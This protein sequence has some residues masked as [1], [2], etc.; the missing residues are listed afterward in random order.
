MAP[1]GESAGTSSPGASE[2]D[3]KGESGQTANPKGDAGNAEENEQAADSAVTF[4]ADYVSKLRKEAAENRTKARD[5]AAKLKEHEEKDKPETEKLRARVAELESEK[6]GWELERRTAKVTAVFA[7]AASKA[8][9]TYPDTIGRLVDPNAIE[10]A[11]GEIMNAPDLVRDVKTRYPN[12]FTRA[13]AGSADGG[14]GNGSKPP[15]SSMNDY[16]RRAAG[17]Q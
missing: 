9:A 10:W 12:L 7:V 15:A 16:I 14:A 2:S 8:G 5:A 3:P 4:S 6:A 13:P 11:D 17:V 1:E